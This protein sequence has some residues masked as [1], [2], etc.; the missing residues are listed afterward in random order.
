MTEG[1]VGLFQE[2]PDEQQALLFA[3]VK[4]HGLAARPELNGWTLPLYPPP[5]LWPR[6]RT[7]LGPFQDPSRTL[8]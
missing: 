6:P 2:L 5:P 8:P 4:L 1:D 7:L 3:R